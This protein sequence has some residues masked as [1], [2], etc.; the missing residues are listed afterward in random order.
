MK[1]RFFTLIELLV[2][3][4]IIAVLASMLLPALRT[5]RRQAKL[6][7]CTSHLKNMGIAHAL[8]QGDWSG[9]MI[10]HYKQCW[11]ED[12]ICP[13]LG[14]KGGYEATSKP[15]AQYGNIFTCGEQPEG[16]FLGNYPSFGRN[17]SI[18]TPGGNWN[19]TPLKLSVFKSPW[20]KVFMAD[21]AK[22]DGISS[23]THFS[24]YEHD[25]NGTL[26][27]RHVGKKCNIA[28][29]DG[30]VKAYGSPPIPGLPPHWSVGAQWISP[31][32]DPPDG[33]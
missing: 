21:D 3:I 33:L 13:Y 15:R 16:N 31:G 14:I 24:P 23:T 1:R 17:N 22:N 10:P 20:G 28:F 18:G 32:Y 30:H 9:Y 25:P 26:S 2:V 4:A 7:T 12:A 27:I 5:A 19:V 29:L 8:Y 11:W 6:I